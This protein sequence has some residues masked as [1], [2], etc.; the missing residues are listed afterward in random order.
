MAEKRHLILGAGT[1]GI[2]CIRTLRQ[3]GDTGEITLISAERPYARMVLP[4]Y[5]N[6]S[7]SE[8]HTETASARQIQAWKVKTMFGRKAASLE[9]GQNKVKLDNGEEIEYDDLLIATGSSAAR[10][11]IPGADGPG[12]HTFWTL[13]DAKGVNKQISPKGHTVVVGA[14]FISFTCFDGI[15]ARSGKVTLIEVAPRI[16]PRM[17]DETGAR[18]ATEWLENLG[19]KVLT[20]VRLKAL[21]RST[22]RPSSPSSRGAGSRP[23]PCCWRPASAPTWTGCARTSPGWRAAGSS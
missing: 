6:Q 9:P 17:V 16:L 11:P 20:G 10:P 19:V 3:L 5:L 21:S 8:S 4:Y 13:A 18:L 1:A 23:I 7:I 12:I 15:L 2:N 14:G 22:A